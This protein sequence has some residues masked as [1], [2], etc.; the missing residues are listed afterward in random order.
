MAPN[1]KLNWLLNNEQIL[2]LCLS[3][4]V[5]DVDGRIEGFA[6]EFLVAYII[7]D[8][9]KGDEI[10]DEEVSEQMQIRITNYTL[11]SLV[12]IDYIDAYPEDDGTTSYTPIIQEEL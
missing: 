1:T 12:A 3:Y 10:T 6:G 5:G 9:P 2:E 7:N 4:I 11:D 8:S